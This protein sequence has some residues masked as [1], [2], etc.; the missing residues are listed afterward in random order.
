MNKKDIVKLLFDKSTADKVKKE[1]LESQ[2]YTFYRTFPFEAPEDED[3]YYERVLFIGPIFETPT[4]DVNIDCPGESFA[5]YN[6]I[7]KAGR[8]EV[9]QKKIRGVMGELRGYMQFFNEV[10]YGVDRSFHKYKDWVAGRWLLSNEVIDVTKQLE[11]AHGGE[12]GFPDF[13]I[14]EMD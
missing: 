10:A 5:K 11:Q 13:D 14:E 1:I 12:T 6:G 7:Y 8:I 3:A 9:N 4:V 2:G